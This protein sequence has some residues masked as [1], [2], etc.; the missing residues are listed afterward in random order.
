MRRNFN[1][2]RYRLSAILIFYAITI[3]DIIIVEE[4][5]RPTG[6]WE[7]IGYYHFAMFQILA[8]IIM[9]AGFIL[10]LDWRFPAY[11]FILLIFGL[12]DT[13]Y[14]LLQGKEIPEQLPW[15]W[16]SPTRIELLLRN[17][18]G[19]SLILLLEFLD[20]RFSFWENFKIKIK[21]MFS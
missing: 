15:L 11:L 13:F 3:A 10:T 17:V 12:E 2:W 14:Y 20:Y 8:P 16:G 7:Y 18:I 4:I 9:I 1:L 19:V 21:K 5:F 6:V